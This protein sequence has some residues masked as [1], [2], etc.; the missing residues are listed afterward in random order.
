[1]QTWK[2]VELIYPCV[3]K[4]YRLETVKPVL[5]AEGAYEQ[6]S[7]YGFEITP[8]V[9][10]PPGVLFLPG[11]RSPHLRAQQLVAG[12][13]WLETG[14]GCTGGGGGWAFQEDVRRPGGVVERG[15]RPGDLRQGGQHRR[16]YAE[17][18]RQA[19]RRS[20]ADG[21]PDRSHDLRNPPEQV[22]RRRAHLVSFRWIPGLASRPRL[23]HCRVA[24][25]KTSQRQ[26]TGKMPC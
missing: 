25:S 2:S 8:L 20:M 15:A 18:G 9:G 12:A 4:D 19:R 14:A 23:D 22:T 24:I 6:G 1:M 16:R 10:T 7:E 21:L 26:K 17:P 11:R 13:A 3:T 5:M